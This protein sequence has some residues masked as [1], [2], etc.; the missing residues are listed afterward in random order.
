MYFNAPS[1]QTSISQHQFPQACHA[2]LLLGIYSKLLYDY[3]ITMCHI[4][5]NLFLTGNINLLTK[6][7]ICNGEIHHNTVYCCGGFEMQAVQ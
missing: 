6:Y 3:C 7:G 1:L 4:K 5:A 2:V